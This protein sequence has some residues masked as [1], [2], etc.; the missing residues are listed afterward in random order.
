MTD[1][2]K[3]VVL[4]TETTG[5]KPGEDQIVELAIASGDGRPLLHERYRPTRLS[6]WPEAQAVH[7]I[8]PEDLAG[9]RT[10]MDDKRRIEAILSGAE[11]FIGYN[12][13]FDI[14]M[15]RGEGI[16]V[17]FLPIADAM[18]RFAPVYGERNKRGGWKWK[19]LVDAAAFF[20]YEWTGSAHGAMADTL[21]TLHVYKQLE[22]LKLAQ[23]AALSA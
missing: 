20:G 17:P 7:G 11:S 9:C 6:E 19:K 2:S 12:L 18:L 21:A 15:L 1:L 13:L 4:D 8:S 14:R 5:L 23:A 10:I 3:V 22:A 16:Y